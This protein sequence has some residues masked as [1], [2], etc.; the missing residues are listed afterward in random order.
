MN[1]QQIRWSEEELLEIVRAV[2]LSVLKDNSKMQSWYKDNGYT[3]IE[4]AA[5][6]TVIATSMPGF[7]VA[8]LSENRK[9]LW[10]DMTFGE[11]YDFFERAQVQFV[12]IHRCN[13]LLHKL[14]IEVYN[15]LYKE[16]RLKFMVKKNSQKAEDLW[17][18]YEK[19]RY[20]S[21]SKDALSTFLAHMRITKEIL[22]PR[23]DKVY[24]SIRD[25][26]IN[27]GWRD[28]ELKARIESV[29]L[30]AK[31]AHHSFNAFFREFEESCGADFSP[32]FADSD[33]HQM[34][35]CF[36]M[37]AESLGF[38]TDTDE[39]GLPDLKGFDCDANIRVKWAWE[40]FIKDLQDNDLMDES[41]LRAIELNPK[42]KEDYERQLEEDA[43]EEFDDGIKKLSDKFKVIKQK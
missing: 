15:L 36:A 4:L 12:I 31:V 37:M 17:E 25:Y 29:F 40:D 42:T 26:M 35:K 2:P 27:L 7:K 11:L 38:K 18:R 1:E 39:F 19:P 13:Y 16:K 10:Q 6:L 33:L 41:A 22:Q 3:K 9:E 5:I 34:V 30:L 23:L 24:E 8:D 14:M 21:K 32:M 28:V 20:Q 43:Q